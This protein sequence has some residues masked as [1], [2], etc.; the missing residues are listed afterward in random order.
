MKI[1][2][3]GAMQEEIAPLLEILKDYTSEEYANNTY[4][5]AKQKGQ[6]KI[7]AYSKNGKGNDTLRVSEKIERDGAKTMLQKGVAGEEKPN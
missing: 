5:F 2:I 1:A 6:E 3:L 7:L 4:Y